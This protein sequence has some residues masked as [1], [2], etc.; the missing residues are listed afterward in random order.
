MLVR[1]TQIVKH[2]I[3]LCIAITAN[4]QAPQQSGSAA[5]TPAPF[6]PMST[7]AKVRYNLVHAVQ[8]TD[9]FQTALGSGLAQW[10]NAPYEWGQGWDAYGTRYGSRFA[11]HL[12]KR[13]VLIAVQ[14]LDG[15]D[16]RRIRSERHGLWPRASDAV[17][18]TFVAQR[19]DGS[20]GFA[21][22]RVIASYSGG[23]ISRQ[24]HPER[25]HTFSAGLGAGSLSL[26]V[27]TGI[28]VLN[29]FMPDILRKMHLRSR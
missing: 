1:L 28:S 18:Y 16:P 5:V 27:E 24:W 9:F 26:G 15:E 3:P 14:S 10:R 4:A 17:K 6:I 21:Y 12:V 29:E 7:A 2:C 22:S 8:P 25:L 13:G 19:D 11:Q 20:R 23:F